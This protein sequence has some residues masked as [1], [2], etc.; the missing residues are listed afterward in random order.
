MTDC[1]EYP[2]NAP[3]IAHDCQDCAQR[4]IEPSWP[5]YKTDC[6]ACEGVMRTSNNQI[7]CPATEAHLQHIENLKTIPATADRRAYIETVERKE[8]RFYADWLRDDYAAWHKASREGV[9]A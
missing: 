8:G 6:P 3:R 7:R 1:H 2:T 4:A 9:K 5:I